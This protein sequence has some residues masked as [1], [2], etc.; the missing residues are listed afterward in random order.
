M[1]DGKEME[2]LACGWRATNKMVVTYLASCSL[3][4]PGVPR[5]KKR[6][7]LLASGAIKTK[8]AAL[9]QGPWWAVSTRATWGK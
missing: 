1:K 7:Q 2:L 6:Y 4:V 5:K 3:T 9:W 8:G